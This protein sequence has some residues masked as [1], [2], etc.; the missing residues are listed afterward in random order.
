VGTRL[1]ATEGPGHASDLAHDLAASGEPRILT[2]GGDGTASEVADGVLRARRGRDVKLG[3]LPGGTGNDFLLHFGVRDLDA[4]VERIATDHARPLDAMR[5]RWGSEAVGGGGEERHVLGAFGVGF[6]TRVADLANRRFK[7][8]GARGYTA[9]V[10]PE[11]ARL[12]APRT[13]VQLDDRALDEPLVLAF[14]CN[15]RYL[16]GGM[17]A[18]PAARPDDGKLDL[19]ALRAIG[20]GGLLRV[21][22]KIFKGTHVGHPC[23]LVERASRVRV[24]PATPERLL[25]DGEVFGSTPADVEAMPA[26]L[27]VLV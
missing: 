20:R 17:D 4:A 23:V 10:F 27:R 18:A 5:V 14:V 16:G 25:G 8:L 1:V 15:T 24:E 7:W 19:V 12:R 3:F 22:P 2:L 13:L 26:A 11:L 21:F 9:A 6:A